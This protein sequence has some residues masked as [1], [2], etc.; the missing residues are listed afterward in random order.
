MKSYKVYV[1]L[2]TDGRRYVG[3][4]SLPLSVRC[5]RTTY[6]GCPEMEKAILELGWSAFRFEK[7][8]G[9]LSRDEASKLE[10]NLIAKYDSTNPDSGFNVAYGGIR[11]KHN[12]ASKQRI[13]QSSTPRDAS[14]CKRKYLEQEPYKRSVTQLTKDGKVVHTFASIRE[15]AKMTGTDPSNIRKCANGYLKTTNQ[16]QWKFTQ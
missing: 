13:S 16:Y 1:L 9:G 2:S 6:K 5:G 3:M 12:S 4:T 11:F 14:F 15:A 10:Q 8:I 7:V